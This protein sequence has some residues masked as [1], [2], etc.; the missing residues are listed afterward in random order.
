MNTMIFNHD[1]QRKYLNPN[2]ID[3]VI[4][5]SKNFPASVQM[6]CMMIS[7]TG[8][9]ISEALSMTTNS[10][11]FS[12]RHVVIRCLKK[13]GKT[14]FRSIPLPP[15]FLNLIGR[16]IKKEKNNG[17]RLWPWSRM[18]GYR[19]IRDVMTAANIRGR[20]ASPKGLRHGF[21][22]RAVQASVPL[23]LVQRWLGHADIKTTAIYT[24]AT[25]PEERRIA[26][27]MWRKTIVGDMKPQGCEPPKGGGAA[28]ENAWVEQNACAPKVVAPVDLL[29]FRL[30]ISPVG[31]SPREISPTIKATS[32]IISTSKD[33]GCT[34]IHFWLKRNRYYL[35]NTKSYVGSPRCERHH[36]PTGCFNLSLGNPDGEINSDLFHRNGVMLTP[37]SRAMGRTTYG[38]Y[39][40]PY[41]LSPDGNSILVAT[42]TK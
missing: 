25:G 36:V 19:R 21:G 12:S 24:N 27:R 4:S 7:Y 31:N 17:E 3:L 10:I 30:P 34:L 1:G 33:A 8:C 41:S 2:E 15:L 39:S 20:H 37:S 6:F 40:N 18:T 16:W 42:V 14:V 26:S 9:R 35:N 29:N 5:H 38:A 22:V 23:T 13:R 32:G 28:V 11:D